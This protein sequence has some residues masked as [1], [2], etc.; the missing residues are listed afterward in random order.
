VLASNLQLVTPERKAAGGLQNIKQ[1][2][3]S[4]ARHKQQQEKNHISMKIEC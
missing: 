3:N 4:A 1:K 2:D